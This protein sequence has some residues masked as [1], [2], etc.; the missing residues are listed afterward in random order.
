M[1]VSI[2]FMGVQFFSF[3]VFA[4]LDFNM[5]KRNNEKYFSLF[6]T[7]CCSDKRSCG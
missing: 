5:K 3:F 4:A 7:L 6:V 2:D 1:L